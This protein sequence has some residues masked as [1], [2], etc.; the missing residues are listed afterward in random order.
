MGIKIKILAFIIGFI[1]FLFI[2]RFIKR[3]SFPPAFAVLWIGI[4]LFLISIPA[5][6]GFY[7]W[8]TYSVIGIID[9][10]HIIYIALIG[11]LLIYVFHLTTKISRMSDQIQELI[12]SNAIIE[13]RLES[14]KK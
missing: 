10:R 13:N 5:F 4:S 11:F 8:L 7:Q 1:F 3:N 12:S 6:E 9:A 14:L 2:L